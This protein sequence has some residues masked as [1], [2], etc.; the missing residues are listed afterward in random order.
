MEKL[1]ENLQ[2][3]N[4]DDL[5]HV[6]QMIHDNK[7]SDSWTKNDV[8]RKILDPSPGVST[9]ADIDSRGRVSGR[10]FYPSRQLDSPALGVY[11]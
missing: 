2:K 10:S 9:F 6:V 3:M 11:I 5:I 7:T 1:A 4:E 8:E